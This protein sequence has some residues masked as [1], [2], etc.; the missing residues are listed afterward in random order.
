[1]AACCG[2]AGLGVGVAIGSVPLL[3][4]AYAIILGAYVLPAVADWRG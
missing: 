1:V 3:I 4:A 2:L